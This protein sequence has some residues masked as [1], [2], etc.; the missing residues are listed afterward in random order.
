MD[1]C[2]GYL[3]EYDYACKCGIYLEYCYGCYR[4]SHEGYF[5]YTDDIIKKQKE[6]VN[7][8]NLWTHK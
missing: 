5:D 1:A 2:N 6:I 8:I 4:V 7:E 3:T